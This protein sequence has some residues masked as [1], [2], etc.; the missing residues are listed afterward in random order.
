MRWRAAA[1]FVLILIAASAS[2]E[3]RAA[4]GTIIKVF[5][6]PSLQRD[7]LTD[8]SGR[9]LYTWLD[10]QVSGVSSCVAVCLLRWTPF[11]PVQGLPIPD[12]TGTADVFGVTNDGA[13]VT[14]NGKPLY[15]HA[16]DIAPGD[17][18]GDQ[19]DGSW[20][21]ATS[22]YKCPTIIPGLLPTPDTR[23]HPAFGQIF[24]DDD[25]LT[26][27]LSLRDRPGTS[28][29][30]GACANTWR[31]YIA[32]ADSNLPAIERPDRS[33]QVTVSGMPLYR[34]IG[35]RNPG[36][37][38]GDGIDG[39]WLVA[40][41]QQL[42]TILRV[43]EQAPFGRIL[44]DSQGRTLYQNAKDGPEISVC[45][46][47]CT[48]AYPPV[49]PRTNDVSL[50][51]GA[52][53]LLGSMFTE[54]G[55]RQVIISGRPLY[56]SARDRRPGDVTGQ[57]VAGGWSVARAPATSNQFSTD[58]LIATDKDVYR[59]GETIWICYRVP[60]RGQIRLLDYTSERSMEFRSEADDGRGDCLTAT[61][62]PPVGF[63]C[64]RMEFVS[65]ARRLIRQTCF[66]VVQ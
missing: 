16:R 55:S 60:S 20:F 61:I 36:D 32:P 47:G 18:N 29:C 43:E 17:V 30:T 64:V 57:S 59:L 9:T 14:R 11:R 7:V 5:F 34:Y 23:D 28:T 66:Q 40:T 33:R 50:L 31:P 53:R 2:Q 19:E 15:Y 37:T 41:P 62:T 8:S 54:N 35:D 26:L 22:C 65:G 6:N 13:Q 44:V 24:V 4:D 12:F 48:A 45:T 3:L 49:Q 46:E 10:D 38:R 27:Y 25:R 58:P 63:E 39:T 56:L 42:A 52:D 21:A 1:L 51:T